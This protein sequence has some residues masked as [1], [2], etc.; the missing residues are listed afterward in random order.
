MEKPTHVHAGGVVL[1]GALDEASEL[2]ELDDFGK[3]LLGFPGGQPQDRAAEPYVLFSRQ[4]LVKAR[5]ELQDRGDPAKTLQLALGGF[6]GAGKELEQRG[7]PAPFSPM[8]PSEPPWG[9]VKSMPRSAQK[10]S[11][12]DRRRTS[13]LMLSMGRL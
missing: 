11:W 1:D 12:N 3:D 5:T 6:D 2:G 13:S 4:V 9:R 10:S 8:I 7:F